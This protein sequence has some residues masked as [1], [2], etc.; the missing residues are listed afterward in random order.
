MYTVYGEP[1]TRAFRVIWMLEELGQSYEVNPVVRQSDEARALNPTAKVPILGVDGDL[2]TDSSAILTYLADKHDALT[3]PAGTLERAKQDAMM[4]R[5]LDELEGVLW[6]ASR[7]TF[8][9]PEEKRVPDVIKS[10]AW[11]FDRNLTKLAEQIDG[12]YLAGD[13]MTIADIV[14]T[15]CLTWAFAIKFPITSDAVKAYA[16]GMRSREAHAKAAA[17]IKR[18]S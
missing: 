15:H 16:K 17:L 9:L 4:H 11:E 10:C 8:I 7:H 2:V 3:Y 14:L 18:P 13:K 1:Y 12:P 6:A 5:V